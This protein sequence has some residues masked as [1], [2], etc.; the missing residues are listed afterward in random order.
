M[1]KITYGDLKSKYMIIQ[2][3]PNLWN[4]CVKGYGTVNNKLN[5]YR[6]LVQLPQKLFDLKIYSIWIIIGQRSLSRL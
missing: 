4:K 5:T 1:E 3:L 6:N 2:K